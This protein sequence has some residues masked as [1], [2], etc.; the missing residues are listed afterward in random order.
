LKSTLYCMMTLAVGV[1]IFSCSSD[2]NSLKNEQTLYTEAQNFSE[3]GDFQSAIKTYEDILKLYPDSPRAYKAQF[4]IAFVYSENL[5][6]YENA[7]INYQKLIEKYPNCDLV[8]DAQ[9]MLRT[10]ENDTL[11]VAPDEGETPSD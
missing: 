5:K 4:L 10:M 1:L 7:K 2:S 11:P 9:Y 6:D 8:D 3:K